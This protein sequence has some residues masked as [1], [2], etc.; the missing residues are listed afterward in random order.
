MRHSLTEWKMAWDKRIAEIEEFFTGD[1]WTPEQIK[2]MDKGQVYVNAPISKWEPNRV[3]VELI[4]L[5]AETFDAL[6]HTRVGVP[7]Y[8]REGDETKVWPKPE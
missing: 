1:Q 3:K 5:A 7:V 2:A 4:P 8:S 6:N